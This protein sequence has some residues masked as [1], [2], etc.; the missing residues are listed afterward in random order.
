MAFCRPIVKT[1]NMSLALATA[2]EST[3]TVST[4]TVSTATVSTASVSTASVSSGHR[5][6]EGPLKVDS[7]AVVTV[8]GVN[9]SFD[10]WLM[11]VTDGSAQL[12][13]DRS[14][15]VAELVKIEC[16]DFFLLG[17]V[18][19]CQAEREQWIVGVTIEHGLYGLRAMAEAIRRSWL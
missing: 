12:R 11:N 7:N 13:I 17:E 18:V 14:I 1:C 5:R 19:Y 2:D 3:A 10:G 8:L 4:A 6:K 9:V 16:T 15:P